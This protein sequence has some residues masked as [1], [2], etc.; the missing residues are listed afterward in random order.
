MKGASTIGL[1]L[2]VALAAP[3]LFGQEARDSTDHPAV[4]YELRVRDVTAAAKFYRDGIGM[5]VVSEDAKEVLLSRAR[6][7]HV[8]VPAR[9]HAP[10]GRLAGRRTP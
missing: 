5:R 1:L 7:Q 6:R 4:V 3:D 10:E 8:S 2:A 9:R